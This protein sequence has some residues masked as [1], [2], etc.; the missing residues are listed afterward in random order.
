VC[1]GGCCCEAA[2]APLLPDT[3]L[4]PPLLLRWLL[5]RALQ[6]LA[7]LAAARREAR[8]AAGAVELESAELRFRTDK[9]GKPVEVD[10]KQV[11]AGLGL[12]TP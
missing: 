11:R 4:P 7:R 2:T 8:L 10:V 9:D 5:Q 3:P 1:C 12:R 6:F